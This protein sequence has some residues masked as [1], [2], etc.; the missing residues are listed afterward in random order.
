MMALEAMAC[1]KPVITIK[2]TATS[3]V[4]SLPELEVDAENLTEDLKVKL[5]FLVGNPERTKVLGRV[6]RSRAEDKFSLE[7]YLDNLVNLY[8]SVITRRK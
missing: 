4:V 7:T 1:G 6:S 3:E 8:S 2:G 5:M